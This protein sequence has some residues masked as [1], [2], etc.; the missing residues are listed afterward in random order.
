MDRLRNT[1][2]PYAWGSRTALAEL[3]G[4]PSPSAG[5]EAELWLGAHPGAPSEL[6]RDGRV[7]TLDAV[8]AA[9][10][11]Q[12]L[13]P[14]AAQA[15][16]EQLPFLLKVLAAARPLSLQAHPTEAQARAGFAREDAEDIPRDS[17]VRNFRD[18][19]HKPELIVALTPFSALCGFRAVGETLKLLRGLGVPELTP[20]LEVL[21]SDGPAAFL[22][23]VL[24]LPGP[25]RDALARGV[26]EAVAQRPVP[27]F[28][29]ECAWGVKLA[30]QY[31]KD[32][33]VVGA[34]CLNLV[35]L[36]PGQGLFLAAGILHSY[37]EGVG[38]EVMANS[39]NVLRGGLTPKNIDVP[40]LLQVLSPDAG[41]ARV[42]TP[43][44]APEAVYDTP[45]AE[46]RLSRLDVRQRVTLERWGPD[47]LLVTKGRVRVS[48]GG[49]EQALAQGES[50]FV[51]FSDGPVAVDGEGTVFRATVRP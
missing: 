49:A 3:M 22:A 15:F 11:A 37:L 46:F 47:I 14:R 45:A 18:P 33:G 40:A 35:E 25:E 43:E 6:E 32:A 39:D 16:A 21:I 24:T 50:V 5:P 28:E 51:P 8:I 2:Q 26:A 34:L 7:E 30:Q 1:I 4:R 23:R 41:P 17:P 27:G 20:H 29:A 38:I 31:P 10:P 44:G 12:A 36:A 48:A 9:A 13:G 19:H 42:L